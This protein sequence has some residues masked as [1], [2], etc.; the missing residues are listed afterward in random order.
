MHQE[1]NSCL[2]LLLEQLGKNGYG[3]YVDMAIRGELK[4][5]FN[6]L[7]DDLR[8]TLRVDEII[9]GFFFLR[10]SYFLH[11]RGS[12]LDQFTSITNLKKATNEK[13]DAK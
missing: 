9:I 13:I 3:Y 6:C 4:E 10:R 7:K 11:L 2:Q 8:G 1:F 12:Y 5:I